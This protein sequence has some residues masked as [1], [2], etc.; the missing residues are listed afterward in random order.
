MNVATVL[1]RL[2]TV[3]NHVDNGIVT[4]IQHDLAFVGNLNKAADE[5][6]AHLSKFSSGPSAAKTAGRVLT[7]VQTAST[8]LARGAEG[9]TLA[10]SSLLDAMSGIAALHVVA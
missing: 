9:L 3:V 2:S 1:Q 10:H 5:F 6:A 8:Q 7:N 4:G